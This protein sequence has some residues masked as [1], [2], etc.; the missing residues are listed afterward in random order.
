MKPV[1]QT[2]FFDPEK[3]GNGNCTEAAVA[4]IL[5]IPLEDVPRFYT[6]EGAADFWEKFE[7]FFEARGLFPVHRSP[8]EPRYDFYYL[9]SGPAPRGCDHMVV[10]RGNDLAH[11]PHPSRAG[12]LKVTHTWVIVLADAARLAA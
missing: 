4:S 11:D 12:L 2:T 8:S 10:M 3:P 5:S 1:D 7:A 6:G 9:A